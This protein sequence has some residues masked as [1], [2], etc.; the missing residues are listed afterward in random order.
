M[1]SLRW[2]L[3]HA[4]SPANHLVY[5]ISVIVGYRGLSLTPCSTCRSRM[6]CPDPYT[7][8]RVRSAYVGVPSEAR[9]V[10]LLDVLLQLG[11]DGLVRTRPLHLRLLPVWCQVRH[12]SQFGQKPLPVLGLSQLKPKRFRAKLWTRWRQRHDAAH[13]RSRCDMETPRGVVS[14]RPFTSSTVQAAQSRHENI[15]QCEDCVLVLEVLDDAVA[16]ELGSLRHVL[17]KRAGLRRLKMW[18]YS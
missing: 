8:R 11:V 7:V 16:V 13:M 12:K 5:I 18:Q 15:A 6:A 10:V 1:G 17:H 9:C 4:C 2:V 3:R 14:S